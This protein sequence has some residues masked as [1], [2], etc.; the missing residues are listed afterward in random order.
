M[1]AAVLL[2]DSL[3]AGWADL[4]FVFGQQLSGGFGLLE[5]LDRGVVAV[6]LFAGFAF[7]PRELVVGAGCEAAFVADNFGV[8]GVGVKLA[9]ATGGTETHDNVGV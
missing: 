5:T 1:V 6:E 3:L 9:R 8:D 2:G 7:M 4:G